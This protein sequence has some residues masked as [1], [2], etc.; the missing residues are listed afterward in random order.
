MSSRP[1]R[2]CERSG[3]TRSPACCRVFPRCISISIN[4]TYFS[5]RHRF[6]CRSRS[7][8]SIALLV[9]SYHTRWSMLYLLVNPAM[10]FG[11]GGLPIVES[12]VAEAEGPAGGG[13]GVAALIEHEGAV[14]GDVGEAAGELHRLGVG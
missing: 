9:L 10:A 7:T 14:D 12:S 8:A 6:S 11:V 1:P 4:Q 13:A 3:G 5:R 2:A